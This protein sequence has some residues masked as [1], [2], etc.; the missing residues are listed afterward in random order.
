M[1]DFHTHA[2]NNEAGIN[3][4]Q[5]VSNTTTSGAEHTF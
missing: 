4:I 2:N 3:S 5:L 1:E